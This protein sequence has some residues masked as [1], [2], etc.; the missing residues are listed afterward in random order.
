MLLS[1]WQHSFVY[2]V[3]FIQEWY[4]VSILSETKI[5]KTDNYIYIVYH[6]WYDRVTKPTRK[7]SNQEK[8][9]PLER[10]CNGDL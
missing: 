9:N 8:T 4:I 1:Y 7:D 6:L 10:F 5:K 2:Y 3:E